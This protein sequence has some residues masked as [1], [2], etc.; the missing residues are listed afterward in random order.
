MQFR[1]FCSKLMAGFQPVR[2]LHSSVGKMNKKIH[3]E[4][5]MDNFRSNDILVARVSKIKDISPTV[6]TLTLTVDKEKITS[7]FR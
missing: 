3:I 4:H 6:R 5:T 1:G 7:S 2:Q